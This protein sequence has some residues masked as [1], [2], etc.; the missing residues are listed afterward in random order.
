MYE[1]EYAYKFYIKGF[2]PGMNKNTHGFLY[3][4]SVEEPIKIIIEK[5][6]VVNKDIFKKHEVITYKKLTRY[7]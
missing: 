4:Y 2:I 6:E 3:I 7:R 5:K 1:N